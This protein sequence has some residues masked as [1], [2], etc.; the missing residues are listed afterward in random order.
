MAGDGMGI[1]FSAGL[2]ARPTDWLFLG[3]TYRSGMSLD[4]TGDTHFDIQGLAD[5]SA[6]PD[7]PVET[8]FTLPDIVAFGIGARLG[9][10]YGEVD[11]DY[12][13]WSAF[14]EI[15]LTFPEDKTGTLTQAIPEYWKNTWTFR[16]GNEF[17]VTDELRLR[18]GIGYDQNP[19]RDDY[20]T[21]MLPD[22]D[23]LFVAAG[24]G[25]RLDFG[26]RLDMSYML[27]TFLTR[28]VDG[29]PCTEADSEC[30][31]DAGEFDPYN[32]DGSLR[33]VGNPFPARY[34]NLAHLLSI[35]VGMEF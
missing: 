3:L 15:P 7:Q 30:F 34:E 6:F 29:A 35:T 21:P 33:F 31:N 17:R 11:I 20:L 8:T 16:F 4:L 26:L 32:P 10:W 23:R 1:G 28:T 27:T 13:F 14:E 9:P 5:T 12:T 19:A 22:A 25:Y 2:Q 18:A 24:A